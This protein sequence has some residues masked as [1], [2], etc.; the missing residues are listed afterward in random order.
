MWARVPNPSPA[1][2]WELP[3]S[4]KKLKLV[5]EGVPDHLGQTNYAEIC[6]LVTKYISK[7]NKIQSRGLQIT[8]H[9]FN[10]VFQIL[11]FQLLDKSAKTNTQNN[12]GGVRPRTL[13]QELCPC[14]PLGDFRPQT[15]CAPRLN[16]GYATAVCRPR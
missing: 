6:I 12:V 14:T 8:C 4:E 1:G 11:V 3:K 9:V 16:P 5:K 2:S 15:P 13:H 7:L 10:Y